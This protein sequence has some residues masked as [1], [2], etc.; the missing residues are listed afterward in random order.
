MYHRLIFLVLC[1]H[2][3]SFLILKS[4]LACMN[5]SFPSSLSSPLFVS[6]AHIFF[7]PCTSSSSFI[8]FVRR[9]EPYIYQLWSSLFSSFLSFVCA[10]IH[11][12]SD[13]IFSWAAIYYLPTYLLSYLS[14]FLLVCLVYGS[15]SFTYI[16]TPLLFLFAFA[17]VVVVVSIFS[18][19]INP[20]IQSS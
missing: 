17:I 1:W 14:L 4:F 3:M 8:P 2:R 19:Q 10:Y 5:L 20:A 15:I 11:T 7:G 9:F 6:C 18:F 16:H 12:Y 13:H